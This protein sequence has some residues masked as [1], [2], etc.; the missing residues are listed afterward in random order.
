M[1]LGQKIENSAGC[2][3]CVV[4]QNIDVPQRGVR[5]LD[6][7]LGVG[8]LGQI[9]RYGDDFTVCLARNLRRRCLER[10]LA[11]GADRDID[12]LAGQGKAIALPI[13]A[14]PP[15]TSAVF[16]FI[17]RS[18]KVPSGQTQRAPIRFSAGG[19]RRQAAETKSRPIDVAANHDEGNPLEHRHVVERAR[20]H[21]D[22][23]RRFA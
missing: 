7:R 3:A 18:M 1:L 19:P 13:P 17:R 15:V 20:I 11:A 5:L 10:L 16:P 23:I 4:Y 21:S 14:L 12:T 2:R 22:Y 8:R 6:K 9:S